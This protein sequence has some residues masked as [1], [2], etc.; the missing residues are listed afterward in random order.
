MP[1]LSPHTGLL[2][3]LLAASTLPSAGEIYVGEKDGHKLYSDTPLVGVRQQRRMEATPRSALRPEDYSRLEAESAP[4]ERLDRE[5][6]QAAATESWRQHEARRRAAETAR[7]RG[8]EPRP[9]ERTGYR[10]AGSGRSGSRLNDAY[11]QR[12]RQLEQAVQD[13]GR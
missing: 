12:Q 2:L 1:R 13:S 9:G 7:D 4:A 6:E 5:R 10:N 8:S 3:T 11:F